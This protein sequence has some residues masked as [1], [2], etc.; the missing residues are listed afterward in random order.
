MLSTVHG[1]DSWLCLEQV[2]FFAWV[3]VRKK[4]SGFIVERVCSSPTRLDRLGWIQKKDMDGHHDEDEDEVEYEV[5]DGV[6]DEV[7]EDEDEEDEEEDEDT[8][9]G[10]S[11]IENDSVSRRRELCEVLAEQ[12]QRLENLR[13]AYEERSR[14]RR[15]NIERGGTRVVRAYHHALRFN[16]GPAAVLLDGEARGGGG[17]EEELRD[18]E[19]KLKSLCEDLA[20]LSQLARLMAWAKRTP[21]YAGELERYRLRFA[22]VTELTLHV[23]TFYSSMQFYGWAPPGMPEKP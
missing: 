20:D 15:R 5:E 13:H 10:D 9:S 6:E 4:R 18:L 23:F 11:A 22:G 21:F 16:P 19:D 2:V 7:E 8:S 14:G 12:R 3:R 1:T 17:E